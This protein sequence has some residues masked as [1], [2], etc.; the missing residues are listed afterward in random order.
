M[1]KT[2]IAMSDRELERIPI[3]ER[4]KNGE[5][6]QNYAWGLLWLWRKQVGRILKKYKEKWVEWLVHWLRWEDSN[7]KKVDDPRIIDIIRN[8][9]FHDCKPIFVTKKI[10]DYYGIKASKETIRHMMVEQWIWHIKER[11]IQKY[12]ALRPRRDSYWEMLQFDGSYHLWFE[13]RNDEWCLLVAQDD[14]TWNINWA[15]FVENESYENVVNFWIEYMERHGIP[16]EIYLD[17]F[18]TYKV[19]HKKATYE[20]ELKTQFDTAMKQLWCHL[21]F[22]NSPQAKW[23]VE[24]CNYTLQ[25]WLVKEMRLLKI[26]TPED[27]NKYLQETFIQWFNTTYSVPAKTNYDLH[28]PLN[29]EQKNNFERIFARKYERSLWRDY[30]LQYKNQYFQVEEPKNKEYVVYPKKKLLF[31]ETIAGEIRIFSWKCLVNYHKL[32]KDIVERNRA[33]YRFNKH[34]AQRKIEK[35]R[36]E[37]RKKEKHKTSKQK[38]QQYKAQKLFEIIKQKKS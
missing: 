37:E 31:E 7:N 18:S 23:R 36:F 11:N 24:K 14:A 21:I 35:A 26:S 38:Q 3:L 27:G 22:A 30:I 12:R 6:T 2:T 17:K 5:I 19:N 10:K 28:K 1:N 8:P 16:K 29:N 4:L 9:D 33:K 34:Q 13:D 32:D 25:D 15:K 20:K